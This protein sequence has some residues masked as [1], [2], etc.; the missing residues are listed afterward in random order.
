MI[1]LKPDKPVHSGILEKPERPQNKN[2]IHYKPGA[3][4][5][6]NR[7][8][9]PKILGDS[10]KKQLEAVAEDGRTKAEHVTE[11]LIANAMT[12]L[13]HSVSAFRTIREIVEP[14]EAESMGGSDRDL[15]RMV[16]LLFIERES[17]MKKAVVHEINGK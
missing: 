4:W 14:T 17:E 7:S 15:T 1:A 9:R 12:G 13:P 8:G 3:E 2:L 16:A 10:L 11:T 6:G 5:T